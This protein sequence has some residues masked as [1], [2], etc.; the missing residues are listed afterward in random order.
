MPAY[1]IIETG[2]CNVVPW[3]LYNAMEPRYLLPFFFFFPPLVGPV[4]LLAPF[5]SFSAP[6]N[7][8]SPSTSIGV[9]ARAPAAASALGGSST[10]RGRCWTLAIWDSNRTL[11]ASNRFRIMDEKDLYMRHVVSSVNLSINFPVFGLN[12]TQYRTFV[13]DF[14]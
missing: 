6:P 7:A 3:M 12:L 14:A 4:A 1:T 11:R 2:Q 5:A 10:N 13:G 8:F 9:P